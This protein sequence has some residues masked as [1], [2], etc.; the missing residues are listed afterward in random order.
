MLK[1]NEVEI[2]RRNISPRKFFSYCR[3]EYKRR[4]G[5]DFGW[6]DEYKDWAEPYYVYNDH[7][8]NEICVTKPFEWQIAERF[9]YNFI[10][11]FEFD[12]E[13]SGNGYMYSV[14]HERGGRDE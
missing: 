11:E 12:G 14:E 4:T 2:E 9:S 13:N 8:E 5:E 7:S 3:R 10:M 6:V 1:Y